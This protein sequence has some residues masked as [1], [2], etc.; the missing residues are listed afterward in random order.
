MKKLSHNAVSLLI[1]NNKAI[2]RMM[3]E[4]DRCEKTIKGWFTQGDRRLA[5]TESVEI[6]SSATGLSKQDLFE[7]ETLVTN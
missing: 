4:F 1:G 5:L 6:M 2:G 3:V 7:N